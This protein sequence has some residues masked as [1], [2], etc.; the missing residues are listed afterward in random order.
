MLALR[1]ADWAV[2]SV[3]AVGLV[4][5]LTRRREKMPYRPRRKT[6]SANKL[7]VQAKQPFHQDPLAACGKAHLECR[8]TGEVH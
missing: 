1:R 8:L 4:L 3:G 5:E 6:D 2:S 7:N